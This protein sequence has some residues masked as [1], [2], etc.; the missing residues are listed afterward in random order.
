VNKYWHV[1]NIGIQN[2]LVY[3]MNFLFRATF[4]LV[5]LMATIYLWRAVYA[6]K[7][8]D[9][10]VAGYSLAGMISYY[11]LVTIVDALTAVTEDDW[12]IAADIRDGN[13]NQF[14]LKPIDYMVY[15]LCLFFSGRLIYVIVAVIPVAIFILYQRHYFV[16]PAHLTQFPLFCL[17]V[18]LTAFLQFFMSY[19]MALLA[20]WVLEVSTFI[21]ILFAFEYIAG[22]HLFP[23]DILPPWVS[24]V[25]QFT[26]FPYQLFF[27]VSIYLGRLGPGDIARGFLIQIGWVIF[28]YFLA[29]FVWGR[30][31]RKYTA[32]G[33]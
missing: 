27:P 26:P 25:L 8:A 11:L 21:F 14:L 10:D 17:S 18:G 32:V 24:A 15:R 31:I 23:I 22:G 9:T 19:T 30:G 5:P 2:T 20:F 16:P 6:S 4:A 7:T 3:R 33:G 12:Q 28:F 1:I 29:R 13:I